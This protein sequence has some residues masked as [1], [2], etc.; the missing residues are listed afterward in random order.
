[1][2]GRLRRETFPFPTQRRELEENEKKGKILKRD[3]KRA[4]RRAMSSAV[5][6]AFTIV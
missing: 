3:L 6:S 4:E 1:M 5:R 2:R